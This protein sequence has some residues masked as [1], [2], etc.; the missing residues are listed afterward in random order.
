M[1]N[2]NIYIRNIRHCLVIIS[3]NTRVNMLV[4]NKNKKYVVIFFRTSRV[5]YKTPLF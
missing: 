5:S 1:Y 3:E 2:I 4:K